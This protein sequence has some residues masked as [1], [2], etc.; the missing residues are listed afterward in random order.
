MIPEPTMAMRSQAVPKN[1]AAALIW[2]DGGVFTAGLWKRQAQ[3][4]VEPLVEEAGASWGVGSPT[5]GQRSS[6]AGVWPVVR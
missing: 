6:G 1:S 2:S 5:S 4:D 3:A